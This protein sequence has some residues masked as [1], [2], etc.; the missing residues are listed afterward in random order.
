[1][2]VVP[3][4]P[5][6]PPD[7]SFALAPGVPLTVPNSPERLALI[8]VESTDPRRPLPYN[9]ELSVLFS[10]VSDSRW[11]VSDPE[12]VLSTDDLQSEE[13]IPLQAGAPYP[14]QG[15][16]F[17]VRDLPETWLGPVRYRALALAVLDGA[18]APMF[19]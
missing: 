2:A 17:L 5:L 9:Y 12:G 15:R 14:D 10:R 6:V 1:M 8:R 4:L 3:V 16:P 11:I 18:P 19:A 13:V 7:E